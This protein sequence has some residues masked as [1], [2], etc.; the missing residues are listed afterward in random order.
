MRDDL[1]K[2]VAIDWDR[3]ILNGSGTASE[4][5]GIMNTPGVGSVTFG[6]AATF[7]KL[8]EFETTVSSANAD[9]NSMAYVTTAASR[10]KWKSA[11]KVSNYPSFLWDS[12]TNGAGQVN[13][14]NAVVT[15]SISGNKVVFGDF[16]Q[17][18]L[19]DW[20]GIDVSVNPYSLDTT[21]LVRVVVQML[22]DVGVRHPASFCVSA[23]SGAQ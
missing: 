22:T 16:S 20:A 19:A 7:A 2:V 18:I 14:Y 3:I 11:V 4:S 10:G 6:A 9:G 17:L 23:D 8:V 5:L 15:N 13:G 21:G 12:G 1:L